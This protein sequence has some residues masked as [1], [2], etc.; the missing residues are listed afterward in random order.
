[1]QRSAVSQ[2]QIIQEKLLYRLERRIFSQ[3]YVNAN[4]SFELKV[5][6]LLE[7]DELI[8]EFHYT[9]RDARLTNVE[10]IA[11]INNKEIHFNRVNSSGGKYVFAAILK[12]DKDWNNFKWIDLKNINFELATKEGYWQTYQ[13]LYGITYYFGHPSMQKDIN[14]SS[15]G[16][17]LRLLTLFSIKCFNEEDIQKSAFKN[18]YSEWLN[19]VAIPRELKQGVWN[20][21]LY[22]LELYKTTSK[23]NKK[24]YN[25]NQTDHN[26]IKVK[27]TIANRSIEGKF[28]LICNI[29]GKENT[30]AINSNSYYD[31]RQKKTIF[32]PD[33]LQSQ[34]GLL[35][36]LNFYGNFSHQTTIDFGDQL[37]DF[38]LTYNQKI[39]NPYFSPT[40]GKVKLKTIEYN[41]IPMLEK[42]QTI[43]YEN[44]NK[45]NKENITL[46]EIGKIG[47]E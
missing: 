24:N 29:F 20:Q 13:K 32:S 27:G 9:N 31:H 11:T 35:L 43:K 36:P 39:S 5:R 19:F 4:E 47:G 33:H 40:I 23:D 3:T 12:K 8:I 21:V 42:W 1:M 14:V 28:Q 44:I 46:E 18:S 15:E 17:N 37:K 26:G 22:D 7:T 6:K 16:I 45:I 10:A 38:K 41:K 25:L 30:I 2:Q 34:L